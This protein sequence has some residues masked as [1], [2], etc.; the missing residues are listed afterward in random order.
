MKIELNVS[1]LNWL[2]LGLSQLVAAT[3]A[4]NKR[5]QALRARLE[6]ALDESLRFGVIDKALKERKAGK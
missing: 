5:L 3:P 1:D 2:L 6:A 4:I